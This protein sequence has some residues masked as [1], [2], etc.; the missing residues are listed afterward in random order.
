MDWLDIGL[1]VI[2][3]VPFILMTFF[4]NNYERRAFRA[5]YEAAVKRFI[6]DKSILGEKDEFPRVYVARSEV[7]ANDYIKRMKIIN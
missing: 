4:R 2:A 7:E 3:L 6:L 1:I 5:G